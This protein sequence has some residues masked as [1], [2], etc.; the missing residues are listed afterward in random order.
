M[1]AEVWAVGAG[2]PL[3]WGGGLCGHLQGPCLGTVRPAESR[4]WGG[5]R[6]GYLRERESPQGPPQP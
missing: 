6:E 1:T 3:A 5:G 4:A 2:L